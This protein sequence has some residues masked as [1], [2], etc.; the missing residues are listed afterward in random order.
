MDRTYRITA[1][2]TITYT[3]DF[4]EGELREMSGLP[5]GATLDEVIED[6]Q[7]TGAISEDLEQHGDVQGQEWRWAE[8]SG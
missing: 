6:L 7:L 1:T 5:E 8:V 2:E 4:T 3:C